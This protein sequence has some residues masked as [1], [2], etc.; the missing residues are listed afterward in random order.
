MF[1][2]WSNLWQ[3]AAIKSGESLLVHGGSGGIGHITLQLARA[4]GIR[5]ITTCGSEEKCRFALEQGAYA[6]ID[7]RR[8][9]F[10][11][12]VNALTE[13]RGVDAVLDIIGGDYLNKNLSCL[14][15]EGRLLQIAV[16]QGPKTDINL[17]PILLK[18]L[19]LTGST[20]RARSVAFKS[21]LAQALLSQVWPLLTSGQIKPH[22]HCLLS[23][24]E[25]S[26]AHELMEMGRHM[27][28]IIL[29]V[30]SKS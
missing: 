16:Q 10:V 18:R 21:A 8:S 23:L 27:G 7:Y 24:A 13:G 15:D 6:A 22:I 4:F 1:T 19:T 12:E 17:L 26:R 30:N 5:A 2:V 28:K 9:D 3:R 25:A 29:N 14:A 20:L 11:Q